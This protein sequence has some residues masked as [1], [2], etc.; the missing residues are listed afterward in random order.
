MILRNWKI[1]RLVNDALFDMLCKAF[2]FDSS[3]V[4][5]GWGIGQ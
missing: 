5:I 3:T 4:R 1:I 2:V